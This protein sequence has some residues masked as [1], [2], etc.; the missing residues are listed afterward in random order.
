MNYHLNTFAAAFLSF[1]FLNIMIINTN[2]AS[3]DF[4]TTRLMATGGAGVASM[5][6]EEATIL[7]P[8]PLA[9]FNISSLYYNKSDATIT[10][11]SSIDDIDYSEGSEAK[12][13]SMIITD[14][15]GN[16]KGSIS[17][18]KKTYKTDTTKQLAASLAS[19]I[20]KS[21]GMGITYVFNINTSNDEDSWKSKENYVNI[22]IT[23]VIGHHLILGLVVFDPF[24]QTDKKPLAI[25]GTQFNYLDFITLILDIGADY[26]KNLSSSSLYKAALQIKVFSDFFIRFGT[27]ES[28]IP[29]ERGSGIGA[30]WVGPKIAINIAIKNTIIKSNIDNID[31]SMNNRKIKD[32]SFSISYR[33]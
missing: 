20:G 33:F 31:N 13:S 18:F 21:S 23:H 28:K 30:G 25:I 6:V 9:F 2:Y 27:F 24:N 5:L 1:L 4:E 14:A 16:L 26:T 11:S 12:N 15:K 3:T 10:D 32:T 22:G 29:A 8:A 19:V 17:Y 7:N